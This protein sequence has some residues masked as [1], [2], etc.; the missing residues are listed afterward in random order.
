MI[1]FFI[2]AFYCKDAAS[3]KRNGERTAFLKHIYSKGGPAFMP[4]P[5]V[6]LRVA[7]IIAQK[8]RLSDGDASLFLLGSLA[9][10][11]VHYREGLVGAA[12]NDIGAVKKTSH[13]CP[14]S[15]ERWGEVT[16]HDGWLAEVNRFYP[17]PREGAD[18]PHDFLALGYAVHVLTDMYNNMTLWVRYRTR[19]PEEAA[20]GYNS[21]YHR[22]LAAID[23]HLYQE[24]EARRILRLLP[25]AKPRDFLGRVTADEINAIRRSLYNEDTGAY[26]G[27]VNRPPADT[28]ANRFITLGQVRDFIGE[29]TEFARSRLSVL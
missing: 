10:D 23:L 16:D 4:F 6:H 24:R 5:V 8:L 25:M 12:F 21:G 27:Y 3:V 11:G 22:D 20:K 9:P 28:A 19:F 1:D 7:G 14:V 2:I 17:I 13:L 26:N 18:A 29:A 15:D